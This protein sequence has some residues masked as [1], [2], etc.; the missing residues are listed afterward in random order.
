MYVWCNDKRVLPLVVGGCVGW[1]WTIV[2][3]SNMLGQQSLGCYL[4]LVVGVHDYQCPFTSCS[5]QAICLPTPI[6]I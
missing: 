6:S 1:H 3:E 2:V 4:V 5:R